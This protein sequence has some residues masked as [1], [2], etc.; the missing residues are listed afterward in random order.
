MITHLDCPHIDR[1]NPII[2]FAKQLTNSDLEYVKGT[3]NMGEFVGTVENKIKRDNFVSFEVNNTWVVRYEMFAEETNRLYFVKQQVCE[4]SQDKDEDHRVVRERIWQM[5]LDREISQLTV[6]MFAFQTLDQSQEVIEF[7][8]TRNEWKRTLGFWPCNCAQKNKKLKQEL[9]ELKD[10]VHR[11]K[12][13]SKKV[14]AASYSHIQSANGDNAM[15]ARGAA[16]E[17][18]DFT[19]R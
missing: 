13:D 11:V 1:S 19:A 6:I 2:D 3:F 10:E 12:V 16:E 4:K 17:E 8:A 18:G 14:V 5:N 7:T 9:D 15:T